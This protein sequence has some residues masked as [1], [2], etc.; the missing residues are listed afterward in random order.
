MKKKLIAL[1][2][3]IAM[4][5]IALIGGTMAYFTDEKAQENTFTAGNVEISLHEA[6][7]TRN[8]TTGHYEAVDQANQR[9][10]DSFDYGK[11]YPAQ[12]IVKDP[13]IT[14]ASPSEA[15]YI[16]A[17]ITVINDD[18]APD[19]H[20]ITD[21]QMVGAPSPLLDINKII[22]GGL[23][24]KTGTYIESYNG[25]KPAFGYTA[26]TGDSI[27]S[28][29][30]YQKKVND[31]KYEFYI[32]I[33]DVMTQDKSV[34]L[35]ESIEIPKEWDNEEMNSLKGLKINVEA[36]AVQQYGFGKCYDAIKAAF[37]GENGAFSILK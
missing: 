13:T 5:A 24:S 2:V 25:L 18:N 14:V 21:L 27:P 19:L 37:G 17:K 26:E 28:Y 3:C 34:T 36:F 35:F 15:T 33:E 9:S 4:L 20:D 32:F 6:V 16:A 29:T 10:T 30:V 23:L 7:V 8:A 22:K 11:I 12:K 1:C 31:H